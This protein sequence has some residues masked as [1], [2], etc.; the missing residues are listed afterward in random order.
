MDYVTPSFYVFSFIMHRISVLV[1]IT[2]ILST[3]Q[4]CSQYSAI[5]SKNMI[6]KHLYWFE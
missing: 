6:Y 1:Q 4:L 5:Y 3:L 2:T